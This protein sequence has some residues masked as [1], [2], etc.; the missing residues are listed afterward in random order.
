[1]NFFYSKGYNELMDFYSFTLDLITA[2]GTE[3]QQQKQSAFAVTYKDNNPKDIVTSLDIALSEFITERIQTTFPDHSIHN[4]EAAEISGNEYQWAIDPIDGSA[5]FARHIPQYAIS[6]GLLHN[7]EPIVGAV[8]D[9][10]T[11]ELFSFEKGRGVF[12]NGEPV[13]VSSITALKQSFVLFAAGRTETQREWAGESYKTLLANVNKTKN[14][15]SSALALCY[16]AAGRIEGVIAG[17]FSTMD[18]AAAVGILRE[19]GGEMITAT[20][21]VAGLSTASQRLYFANTQA[22]AENLRSLLE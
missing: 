10:S 22:T 17:T 8:L 18:I 15:S 3:L 7:G 2:A 11:G 21:E 9:P 5:A 14:F 6:I 1:L 12:L 16:I 20:G 13:Q 19:A 4:E